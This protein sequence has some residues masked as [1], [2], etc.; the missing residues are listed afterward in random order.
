MINLIC[1][2]KDSFKRRYFT[3]RLSLKE[4]KLF[5]KQ[6]PFRQIGLDSAGSI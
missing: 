1:T 5:G 2:E 6:K 4:N 3:L